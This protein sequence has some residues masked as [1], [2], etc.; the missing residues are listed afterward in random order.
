[1]FIKNFLLRYF[2]ER[3]ILLLSFVIGFLLLPGILILDNLLV[4]NIFIVLFG[5]SVVGNFTISFSIAS[6]LLPEYSNS[7]SGLIFAFSNIGIIVFQYITGYMSEYQSKSSVLYVN[8][9]L[10]FVLIIITSFVNYHWKFK[11]DKR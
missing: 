2:S 11:K 4:K 3:K 7:A 1:M 6:D 9:A 10:L 5:I 8:I